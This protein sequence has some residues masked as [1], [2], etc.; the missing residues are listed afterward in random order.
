MTDCWYETISALLAK[1]STDLPPDVEAALRRGLASE[2][3]GSNAAQALEAILENV[4][5]ARQRRQPLCQDTGT[6]LFWIEFPAGLHLAPLRD[7][8]EKAVADATQQG[9]LRQNCVDPLTGQNR[10][11]NLG[12][13]APL[14][15]F[16]E[17]SGETVRLS[18]MLKGGGSENVGVQYAL[19][20][21]ALQAGRDLEGARRCLL[22][23]VHQAQGHG[24]AP[25]ILG[26]CIGGDRTGGYLESKRQLLRPLD[27]PNPVPVLRK[28][29]EQVLD[30]ANQLGIGPMGFGG[31]TSLLG[32]K[33]GTRD[34]VPAS[35]FVTVSYMCWACRRQQLEATSDGRLLR[36]L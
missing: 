32:V 6:L 31:K 13:G 2:N 5:L 22:Q 30:E 20:F 16:E 26:V 35:Y 34:R 7:A 18:L 23:A 17:H 8:L 10:G 4:A 33:I 25:G 11:N 24:C 9:L 29:E 3:P 19:P 12:N 14:L 27:H 21:A 36:W 28:M 1:T 15:H